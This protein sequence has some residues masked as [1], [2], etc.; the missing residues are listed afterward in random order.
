VLT[1]VANKWRIV[2]IHWSFDDRAVH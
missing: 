1:R 2:H